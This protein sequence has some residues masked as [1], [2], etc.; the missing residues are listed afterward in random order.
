MTPD[1]YVQHAGVW[2]ALFSG[3]MY[4]S[5]ESRWHDREECRDR[6]IAQL[7]ELRREAPPWLKE[8]K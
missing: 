3:C 1:N 6:Y 8:G 2:E 4:C 5:N 7:R